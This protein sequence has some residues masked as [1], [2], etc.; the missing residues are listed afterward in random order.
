VKRGTSLGIADIMH[1]SLPGRNQSLYACDMPLLSKN[2]QFRGS[3]NDPRKVDKYPLGYVHESFVTRMP[4]PNYWKIDQGLRFL[5]FTRANTFEERTRLIE[6]TL[7]QGAEAGSIEELKNWASELFPVYSADGEH[8]LDFD[9]VGLDVFGVVNYSVHMIG[10]VKT[11]D[12]QQKFWVPRRSTTKK[13]FPGMLDNS[14]G[15][16][17][18]SGEKPIGCIVRECE[19]EISVDPTYTRTNIKFCGITSYQM[20]KTDLGRP[21]CQLQTQ[22]LYEMEFA[23]EV[24]PEIGDGEVG[25]IYLKTLDEVRAALAN[26]EF[27]LNCGMTWLSYLVRHGHL[28]PENEPDLAEICARLHRKHDLFKPL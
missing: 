6:N 22:Y 5:A 20:A 24:I 17:L 9:G 16:S 1:R 2:E 4:W 8:L 27:K 23:K 3:W 14:V 13:N 12:G 25:E 15:G 10:W 18:S 11:Q 21:G 28:T 19:E 26:G 7:R